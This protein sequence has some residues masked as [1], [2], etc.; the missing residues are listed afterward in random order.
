MPRPA[1][2][3]RN[4]VSAWIIRSTRVLAPDRAPGTRCRVRSRAP[5][6]SPPTCATG[7]RVFTPSR[8]KRT[9]TQALSSGFSPR[10]NTIHQPRPAQATATTRATT[11]STAPQ[12][13]AHRAA[14]TASG[15]EETNRP[16]TVQRPAIRPSVVSRFMTL[17]LSQRRR[18]SGARHSGNGVETKQRRCTSARC[19]FDGRC[20]SP[21]GHSAGETGKPTGPSKAAQPTPPKAL[22]P[23]ASPPKHRRPSIAA[24]LPYGASSS[25]P[26]FGR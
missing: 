12:P 8:T 24:S 22:P 18:P 10:G 20:L 19:S 25:P 14:A 9:L 17:F 13:D 23:K 1:T 3:N 5:I 21:P 6:R 7:S 2:V 16:I 26:G 11:T 15:P 4:W